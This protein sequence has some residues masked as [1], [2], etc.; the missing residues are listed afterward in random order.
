MP[1]Q[2]IVDGRER[3]QATAGHVESQLRNLADVNQEIA[4]ALQ[5]DAEAHAPVRTGELAAAFG[6][7]VD[8]TSATVTNSA[9]HAPFVEFGTRFMDAQKFMPADPAELIV[10]IY[11][12]HVN[13]LLST[14]KGR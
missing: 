10:P 2:L 1:D 12:D 13:Q 6:T 3:F 11:L 14:I 5:D 8:A 4:A 7:R 9:G